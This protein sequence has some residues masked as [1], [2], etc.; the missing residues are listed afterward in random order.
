MSEYPK[1]GHTPSSFDKHDSTTEGRES[2]LFSFF[3]PYAV[4]KE[5]TGSSQ[6]YNGPGTT[7]V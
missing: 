1:L 4:T 7:L 5:C 2:L 3:A 6:K